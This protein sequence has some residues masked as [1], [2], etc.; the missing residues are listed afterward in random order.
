MQQLE[1]QFCVVGS[2]ISGLTAA[3]RLRKAGATVIVLEAGERVG[4]R[5][6]TA[7]LTD[8]KT[9][10]EI[11]AEWISDDMLQ[12]AIRK[13]MADLEMDQHVSFPTLPQYIKGKNVFVD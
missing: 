5:I 11:G 1:A 2:G 3:Y 8:E 9:V 12:P 7:K 13:L 6:Y 10:F 4:G